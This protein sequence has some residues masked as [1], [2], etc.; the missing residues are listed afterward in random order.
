MARRC[1]VLTEKQSRFVEEY[2][3]DLNATQA[4]T[5]AGY[6]PRTANEQGARLLANVSVSAVLAERIAARSERTQITQD[7][8]L[9]SVFET[10]ERCKQAE[11]VL[12]RKG[13][14]MM[15]E[16]ADGDMVPAYVFNAGAV[17]KGCELL[18]KH[19][20]MFKEQ[21]TVNGQHTHTYE[22]TGISQILGIAEQAV[23]DAESQLH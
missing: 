11:A 5:R 7:Y 2:L 6:S 15:V 19:L 21:V 12:D 16:N 23:R 20:G 3:V 17:L 1:N 8:V 22:P 18:G 14:P 13:D 10:V 9:Q 4:A